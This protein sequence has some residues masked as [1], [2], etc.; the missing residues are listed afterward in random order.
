MTVKDDKYGRDVVVT[1]ADKLFMTWLG[2]EE[3]ELAEENPG[4]GEADAAVG[5]V[6]GGPVGGVVIDVEEVDDVAVSNAIGEVAERAG[7]EGVGGKVDFAFMP[8]E[9]AGPV[10][11]EGDEGAAD[12]AEDKVV[13]G[14]EA[15]GDAGVA[16]V[17]EVEEAGDDRHGADGSEGALR[18]FLGEL[19]ERE[20]AEEE[21]QNPTGGRREGLDVV[22]D[23]SS[24]KNG[25]S[26]LTGKPVLRQLC[27]QVKLK[28]NDS[29]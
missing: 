18:P 14:H 7:E 21:E 24:G 23:T 10:D 11:A 8:V 3:A 26:L 2:W 16:D 27:R 20:E 5:D 28:R 25:V 19:I 9:L 15:E 17:G 6:E 12:E 13:A 4:D 1:Q 22:M 29:G